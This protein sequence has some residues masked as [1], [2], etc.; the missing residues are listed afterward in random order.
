MAIY[1]ARAA[2]SRLDPA[3]MAEWAEIPPAIVSDCMNRSGTMA[4]EM[5]PLAPGMRLAA[6][7]RTVQCMVGDNGAIHAA[8]RIAGEGD[9]LVI[10]AGGFGGTAVWGGLLTQAAMAAGLSGVVVDGAVR[11]VAEICELGFP[12]FAVARV[13]A[14]PHKGWGGTIDAN[15]AC[16][17][18][19]VRPGDII[20]GDDDGIAVVPLEREAALLSASHAKL[21][22]EEGQ[23]EKLRS[24]VSL[25]Q[26]M[27]LPE[28]EWID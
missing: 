24:G 19:V 18:A 25:A 4:A 14:G 15:V 3:R 7:A 10:A 5:K 2:F 16:A 9:V 12:C 28:P 21:K 17:G 20:I 22:A 8:I 13:P 23:L 11:D 1:R 6:Q 26:Q 27:D